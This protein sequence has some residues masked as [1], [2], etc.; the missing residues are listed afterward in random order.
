MPGW[1]GQASPLGI[2]IPLNIT[3]QKPENT[4]FIPLVLLP[5]QTARTHPVA[6]GKELV[7]LSM[8]ETGVAEEGAGC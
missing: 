6:Q 2:L 3:A 8:E 5:R 1:L 7:P 4:G